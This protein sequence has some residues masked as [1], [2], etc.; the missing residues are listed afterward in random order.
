MIEYNLYFGN[1][2]KFKKITVYESGYLD[3]AVCF[4]QSPNKCMRKL[5]NLH[6]RNLQGL[7]QPIVLAYL[8]PIVSLPR[9]QY[10][11]FANEKL[12]KESI[13]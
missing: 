12:M 5:I 11:L 10:V 9:R 3:F 13:F 4:S 6:L 7:L 8:Q 1:N 2:G